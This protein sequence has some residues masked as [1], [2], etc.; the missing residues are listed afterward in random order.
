[1]IGKTFPEK[2][3]VFTSWNRMATSKY[4][5][6]RWM[7]IA[8]GRFAPRVQPSRAGAGVGSERFLPHH[9]NFAPA[10]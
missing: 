1:V 6:G 8:G 4:T 5:R 10:A 7:R 2:C 9:V 3:K